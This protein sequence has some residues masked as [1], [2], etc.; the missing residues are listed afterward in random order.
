MIIK[1]VFLPAENITYPLELVRPLTNIEGELFD[2][3]CVTENADF[4][5]YSELEEKGFLGDCEK[6]PVRVNEDKNGRRYSHIDAIFNRHRTGQVS[7]QVLFAFEDKHH[8]LE[9]YENMCVDHINPSI[10]VDNGLKNIRWVTH[11][12][13]MKAAAETGVMTKKY[14]KPLIEEICQMISD[15]KQR[16][17]IMET[18][19]VNGSIVDDIHSGRS[20]K[21]ISEKYLDKGFVYSDKHR[22]PR[23]ERLEEAHNICRMLSEGYPNSE[24]CR[25]LGVASGLVT[26]VKN[27]ESYKDI[28][29]E[30]RLNNK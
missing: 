24:I 26:S 25:T 1:K 2:D 3:L 6:N 15:G 8:D 11:E 14:T 13:N 10:P 28:A 27:G 22:R 18:L 20:H 4:Y 12:E 29:A 21:V 19:S 23:S 30:Y 5:R 17:E 9:W 16:C 7:R